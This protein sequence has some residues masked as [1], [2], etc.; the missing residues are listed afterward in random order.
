MLCNKYTFNEN[1]C[2]TYYVENR[3]N[4][5]SW[6]YQRQ[7]QNFENVTIETPISCYLN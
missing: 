3:E 2:K 4:L 7:M 5:L 6:F 1:L